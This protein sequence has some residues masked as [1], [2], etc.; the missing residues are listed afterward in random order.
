M[1]KTIIKV[2]NL[3]YQTYTLNGKPL[4]NED[5]KK[6]YVFKSKHD[7]YYYYINILK[8]FNYRHPEFIE[9]K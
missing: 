3:Y 2:N 4:F 7:A 6:A 1:K 8:F 9:V 5:V